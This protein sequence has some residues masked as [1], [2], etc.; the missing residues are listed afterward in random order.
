MCAHVLQLTKLH[1]F[2][3]RYEFVQE[4]CLSWR[5]KIIKILWHL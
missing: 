2:E 4:I 3:G 1:S 5:C